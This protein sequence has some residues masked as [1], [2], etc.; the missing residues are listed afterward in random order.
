MNEQAPPTEQQYAPAPKSGGG[1]KKFA[2]GCG[3]AL[4]ILVI[5]GA[6]AGWFIAKNAR[7]WTASGAAAIMNEAVDQSTLPD[8]QK[9]TIKSRIEQLRVDFTAGDITLKEIGE[10]MEN[11]DV[12]KLIGAGL[13]QYV[14]SGIIQ[15]SAL[16]D[17]EK[18][19]GKQAL[20]RVAHGMMDGQVTMSDFKQV[21]TPIL[22]NPGSDDYQLKSN[23]TPEELKQVINNAT[24]IAD[25]AGIAEDV[26]ELDFAERVNEAFDQA[27]GTP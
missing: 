5:L 26:E 7:A 23:P 14:G 3:I 15:A 20:N 19:D 22:E 27:L 25:Q 2:I 8:D 18:A 17:E 6:V 9:Q 4:L 16:S 24:D 10:A 13:A 1:C 12:E 21:I 11:L